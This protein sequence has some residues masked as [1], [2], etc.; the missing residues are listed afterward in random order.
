MA[1][2]PNANPKTPVMTKKPRDEDGMRMT[3]KK[4]EADESCDDKSDISGFT[5]NTNNQPYKKPNS[6]EFKTPNAPPRQMKKFFG[7]RKQEGDESYDDSSSY[8]EVPLLGKRE[9]EK[10]VSDISQI[11]L[12][13]FVDKTP[14]PQGR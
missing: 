8:P 14:P 10:S 11:D 12:P 13:Q 1:L 5:D 3:H 4:K 7:Q 9:Q 2:S 6:S